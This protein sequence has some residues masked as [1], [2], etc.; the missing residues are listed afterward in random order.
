MTN[1]SKA[2]PPSRDTDR[3]AKARPMKFTKDTMPQIEAWSKIF[4]IVA[5]LSAAFFAL[6]QFN[7]S[8]TQQKEELRWKRAA[9]AR[10]MV[11]KMLEDDGWDAMLMLDWGEKGREFEIKNGLWDIV[12]EGDVY[13][14][15]AIENRVFTDKEVF[16]RDRFDRLFFLVGQLQSAATAN[17]VKIKDVRF[18]LTWY[19]AH[20]MREHKELFE[21]YMKRFSPPEALKFFRGLKEWS[22]AKEP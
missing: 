8:L 5:G 3:G 11:N 10:D 20:R 22:G 18:P 21:E 17:L 12:T 13:R 9:L 4:G 7:H 1:S 6:L 15:L 19:A 16:I 2:K 14:A